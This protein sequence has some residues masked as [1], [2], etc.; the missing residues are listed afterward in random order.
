MEKQTEQNASSFLA[1]VPGRASTTWELRVW[2]RQMLS[3]EIY[4]ARLY[5]LVSPREKLRL[6]QGLICPGSPKP[7]GL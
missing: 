1:E 2:S 3:S 7:P 5:H 4:E 6:R